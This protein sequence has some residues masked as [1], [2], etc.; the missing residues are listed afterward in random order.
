M[1]ELIKAIVCPIVDHPEDVHISSEQSNARTTYYLS[2]HKEDMG[3]VIGKHGRMASAIRSVIHA[4]G[5]AHHE[6]VTLT[7]RE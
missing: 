3:K 5:V 2:V 7:I 4:T 6:N 1:D